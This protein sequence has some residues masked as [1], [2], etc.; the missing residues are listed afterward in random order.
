MLRGWGTTDIWGQIILFVSRT[1]ET[2][3]GSGKLQESL[4][5]AH[6]HKDEW[7]LCCCH[8]AQCLGFGFVSLLNKTSAFTRKVTAR[9]DSGRAFYFPMWRQFL[10]YFRT[11][12]YRADNSQEKDTL[13]S[14][15]E[16]DIKTVQQLFKVRP[17]S[18]LH[19]RE[20]N[21]GGK[22]AGRQVLWGEPEDT[23]V[24]LERR[25]LRG[26]LTAPWSSLRRGSRGRCHPL[27]PG[28]WW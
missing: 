23:L 13:Q 7:P 21:K 6:R 1:V 25:R 11:H 3:G 15:N 9:L 24:N 10:L 16:E 20:G 18:R 17:F 12:S 4:T 14:E 28:N 26:D 19:L 27:L 22:R 5:F 2:T 8:S